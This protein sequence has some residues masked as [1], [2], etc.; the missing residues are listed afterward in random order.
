MTSAPI[1]TAARILPLRL[2][3]VCIA[4]AA[5]NAADMLTKA[6]GLVRDNS[7]LELRLDYVSQPASALPKIKRFRELHP[8][9]VVIGTCRRAVN[10]G[11]FRGSVASQLEILG[12]AAAAGCQLVDLELQS[13]VDAKRGSVE[14]LRSKAAVIL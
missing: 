13:A 11:K 10:G 9:A 3:R 2:P 4:L 12:K 14:R 5:P 1:T 6:E 7:L 8:S